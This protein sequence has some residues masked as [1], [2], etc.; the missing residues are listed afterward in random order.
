M[1]I[2]FPQRSLCCWLLSSAHEADY[3]I[4]APPMK[5]TITTTRICQVIRAGQVEY[6]A[7][8]DWQRQLVG[9]RSAGRRSDMLLLLEH[10]PTIT[11]GRAAQS[12]HVLFSGEQLARRGVALVASDR[13]GDATYHAPGQLVGYP[14]IKLSRY[15]G[16]VGRYVRNIEEVLIRTLADFSISADRAAGLAGVWVQEG[17]AKI[18][19]IGV[20][21]SASGVTS[22]GFALNIAPDLRGFDQ[23]VPCGI[24]D[25]SVTSMATLLGVAPIQEDVIE[26]LL[27]HFADIFAVELIDA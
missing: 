4:L 18:A 8:W 17:S 11:L 24:R 15:G 12:E 14:I 7:A 19:A 13:G 27:N 25:R 6:Q 22:H 1:W 2:A 16:D 3:G 23:I 26:R 20:R 10:P 21:V 5:A 9:E